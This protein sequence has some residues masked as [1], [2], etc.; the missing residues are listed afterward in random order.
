MA[1]CSGF[2]FVLVLRFSD[3]LE[4]C[5]SGGLVLWFSGGLV[6]PA[7]AAHRLTLLSHVSPPAAAPIIRRK[8]RDCASDS[9]IIIPE[10]DISSDGSKYLPTIARDR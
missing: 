2:Q 7:K 5:F 3:G 10:S 6:H 8:P 4:L 9:R 1:W